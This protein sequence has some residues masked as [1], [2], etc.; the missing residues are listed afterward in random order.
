MTARDKAAELFS[1]MY[2][3][4]PLTGSIIHLNKLKKCAKQCALIAVELKKNGL[5]SINDTPPIKRLEDKF[6]IQ[7]WN[8]V[9]QEIEKIQ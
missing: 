6:Y 9:I 5:P 1:K 3:E 4:T 8:N 7:Y 2:E